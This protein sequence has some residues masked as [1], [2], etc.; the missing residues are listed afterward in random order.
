MYLHPSVIPSVTQFLG[1]F[2]GLGLAL[3]PDVVVPEAEHGVHM[4]QRSSF[5]FLSLAGFEPAN[6]MAASVTTKLLRTPW[7]LYSVFEI[8]DEIT[9]RII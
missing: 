5:K 1:E 8:I 7:L 4:K 2:P 9:I 6:P 3:V